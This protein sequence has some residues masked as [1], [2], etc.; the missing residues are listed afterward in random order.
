MPISR[1]RPKLKRTITADAAREHTH[2]IDAAAASA[3]SQ[4]LGS[5]MFMVGYAC[6]LGA[7]AV[8]SAI[9]RA[10]ELNGRQSR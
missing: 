10:I 5:N 3:C 9:E 6:R 4:S 1:C 7:S 8:S 2:F